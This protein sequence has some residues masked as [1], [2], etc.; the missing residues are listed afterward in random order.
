MDPDQ[1]FQAVEIDLPDIEIF[2]SNYLMR[3]IDE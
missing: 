3:L 1:H 2:H